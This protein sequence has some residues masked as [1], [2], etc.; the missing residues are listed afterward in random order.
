MRKIF[1][2]IIGLLAVGI[3]NAQQTPADKQTKNIIINNCFIHIGNG[4]TIKD[5]AVSFFDGKLTYVGKS[6]ILNDTLIG[7]SII[8]DANG[9]HL[10]PGFIAANSTLGLVEIDA[11]RSTR[12]LD[13]LGDFLPHI[14]SL[15]A[16]NAES[17][18]IESVRQNGV[19]IAQV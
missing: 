6:I 14:R 12:D 3:N 8:I 17:K 10:Y 1:L 7:E 9:K 19:L 13:E 5:G 18:I 16:Y 2:A 4:N 15:V 11:V